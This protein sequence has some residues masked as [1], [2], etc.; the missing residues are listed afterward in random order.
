MKREEQD[1]QHLQRTRTFT[2][3]KNHQQKHLSNVPQ[4]AKAKDGIET[5]EA[6][7]S[8]GVLLWS[9]QN[10]FAHLGNKFP[11]TR[12]NATMLNLYP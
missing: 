10:S 1:T 2:L 8:R 6:Q 11:A 7:I 4:H 12:G 9:L 5:R 3:P